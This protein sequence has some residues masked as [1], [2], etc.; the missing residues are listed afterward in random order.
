MLNNEFTVKRFYVCAAKVLLVLVVLSPFLTSAHAQITEPANRDR[1]I[2]QVVTQLMGRD[3]ISQPKMPF[4]APYANRTLNNLL[5]VLDPQKMYFYQSD[6]DFFMGQETNLG[7]LYKDGDISLGYKLYK[8]YLERVDERHNFMLEVLK[9]PQ[10]FTL[11]EQITVKRE[12][13]TYPKTPAEARERARLRVK[14]DILS[15]LVDE[16]REKK[17]EK[18]PASDKAAEN[19]GD[20]AADK[21][22]KTRSEVLSE[23]TDKLTR[24]Y[25]SVSKRMHQI[26][27]DEL[28]EMYLTAMCTA[29]DPHTSYMSPSTEENF[30]IAM[31]LK[32]DGIGASLVSE[33]GYCV[34]KRIITGGAAD[35]EGTLQNED[36]IISV[37]QGED[38]PMEDIVDMKLND[39]VK[40]VRGKEGTLVRLEVIP[41]DGGAKKIIKIVRSKIELKD[42]EAKGEVFQAGTKPTGN[43]YKIG[44]INLPSFYMDIDGARRGDPNYKSTTRDVTR[45]LKNFKEN[46]V[47]AV[48]MDLRMNGGGSLQ[49]AIGLTGLFI[50]LGSV[51]QVKDPKGRVQSL[52]DEVSGVEWNGPLVVVINKLSASASE[53]FAGAIQD[54]KRGLIVGD[55][56]T[57]G[58][59]S[60]QTLESLSRELFGF[61]PIT[62][63]PKLGEL[64]VTIQQFYRPLGDST[65]ERGVKS[66]VIIPAITSHM[67]LGEADLDYALPFDQVKPQKISLY[68]YVNNTIAPQIAPLSENRVKNNL[69]FQKLQK[70]I[71]F[72]LRQKE[73]KTVTL[74]EKLFR[75]ERSDL[76]DQEQEDLEKKAMAEANEIKRDYYLEE[77]FNITIDYVKILNNAGLIGKK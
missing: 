30:E 3:H 57:H 4:G 59:G 50:D 2:T 14:Y 26:D 38:G 67:D 37:G 16:M 5:K 21:P 36:K 12:D 52:D 43:P 6:I 34:V 69:E 55:I 7:T 10:D 51:V 66:D 58:K 63:P 33:D 56:T 11:D 72:Y 46:N 29:Y 49:E 75:A 8:T 53:I 60:V 71:D 18:E 35:K 31:R 39:V 61:T 17:S 74:N 73:K 40:K 64:K 25:K 44:V 1:I 68:P 23:I 65:Q 48:V 47:D 41:A 15:M 42:S 28:L 20:K 27:G 76:L 62:N 54:Y 9:Q 70:K 22:E 45:I 77:V 19:T 13:L 32:L 24:R